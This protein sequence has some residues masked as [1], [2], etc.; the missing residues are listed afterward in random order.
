MDRDEE[1]RYTPTRSDEEI[2]SVIR[3]GRPPA[4]TASSIANAV[5]LTRPSVYERLRALEEAGGVESANLT[6]RVKIWWIPER[7]YKVFTWLF[8][9]TSNSQ[10]TPGGSTELIAGVLSP[11]R[12]C[13][14]GSLGRFFTT[15]EGNE[16]D[17][18][19]SRCLDAHFVISLNRFL[20]I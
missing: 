18:V 7:L 11:A 5:E 4:Q 8:P 17:C 10:L 6:K 14:S 9:S 16:A 20:N 13:I 19:F 15:V 2:L 3:E 12:E 1:G